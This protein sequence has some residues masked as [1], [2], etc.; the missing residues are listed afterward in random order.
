MSDIK[1]TASPVAAQATTPVAGQ[2]TSP[3]AAQDANVR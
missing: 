3:V 1:S 2:A